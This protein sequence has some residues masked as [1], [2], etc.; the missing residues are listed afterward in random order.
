MK[1]SENRTLTTS[2]ANFSVLNSSKNEQKIPILSISHREN[3]QDNDFRFRFW[4]N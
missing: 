4:K 3:A 1:N 2:K